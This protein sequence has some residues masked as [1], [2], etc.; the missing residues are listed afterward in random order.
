VHQGRVT[1]SKNAHSEPHRVTA[2]P[3][4]LLHGSNAVLGRLLLFIHYCLMLT[5]WWS[6][7]YLNAPQPALSRQPRITRIQLSFFLFVLPV[8]LVVLLNT[9]P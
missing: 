6:S 2:A 5:S 4:L 7:S 8:R 9:R 3:P 1:F